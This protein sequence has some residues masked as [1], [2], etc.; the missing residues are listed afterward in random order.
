MKRIHAILFIGFAKLGFCGDPWYTI[1]L[2][3]FPALT[4]NGSNSMITLQAPDGSAKPCCA[5]YSVNQIQIT[6]PTGKESQWLS[7]ILSAIS[8]GKNIRVTGV[9]NDVSGTKW[10]TSGTANPA[11]ITLVPVGQ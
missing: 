4:V 9:Y 1:P 10:I 2:S 8:T 6:P 11:Y 5:G 7:I 3:T